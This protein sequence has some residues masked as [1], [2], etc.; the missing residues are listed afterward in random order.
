MVTAPRV[1]RWIDLAGAYNVRD[2]GGLAAAGGVVR[3]GVLLRGDNLDSLTAGDIA[4]LGDQVGLRGVVDLRAPFENPREA[5]WFSGLGISWLHEPLLDLTGLTDPSVRPGQAGGYDFAKLYA[6]MLES[7]GAGLVRVLD[8]LVS[9]SR[10]PALVH[11]AAGKDRT[12]V[13]VAV[14]LAAADVE[15]AAIIADYLATA[16]RIQLVREALAHRE[17]YQH[18]REQASAGRSAPAPVVDPQA[19]IGALDFLDATHGGAAGF[20][21]AHGATRVQIDRWRHMIIEPR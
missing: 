14:L 12:G 16:E 5:D 21:L 7:A 8:F 20:L 18:L 3:P 6:T 15:R 2:L 11:C 9:G 19:I 10:A 4:V 1:P 17:E 13:T